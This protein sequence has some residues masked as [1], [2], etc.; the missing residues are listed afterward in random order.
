MPGTPRDIAYLESK[1]ETGDIPTQQDF[2]DLFQSFVHY[3]KVVQTEGSSTSDIMSQ[4]AVTDALNALRDGVP[5]QGNTLNKL[6]ELIL[7]RTAVAEVYNDIFEIVAD[8]ANQENDAL[9]WVVDAS[10]DDTVDSGWAIY[11]KVDSTDDF[12]NDYVKV[13]E[14]EGLDIVI[15]DANYDQKGIVEFATEAETKGYSEELAVNPYGLNLALDSRLPNGITR[16]VHCVVATTENINLSSPPSEIDGFTGYYNRGF[17]LQHPIL[18]KNQT[19]PTQNGI[20]YWDGFSALV[21]WPGFDSATTSLRNKEHW[22]LVVHVTSGDVNKGKLFINRAETDEGFDPNFYPD[23]D[24]QLYAPGGS[25]GFAISE[26]YADVAALLAGQGGQDENA[27]YLVQDAS[28]DSTVTSGWA[29][30]QKLAGSTADLA[31]YQKIAEQESLDVVINDATESVKGIVELADIDETVAGTDANRVITPLT[32]TAAYR[33]SQSTGDI[34]FSTPRVYG[35]DSLPVTGNLTHDLTNARLGFVQKIYHEDSAEPTYPSGWVKIA[36]EYVPDEL[37]LIFVEFCGSGRVEY[38]I[39]QATPREAGIF[40]KTGKLTVAQIETLGTGGGIDIV[41]APGAGKAIQ[42][43]NAFFKYPYQTTPYGST[44]DE[45][46]FEVGLS[47]LTDN[48]LLLSLTTTSWAH[49]P[50]KMNAGMTTY[51]NL[52]LKLKCPTGNPSGGDSELHYTVFYSIVDTEH[53]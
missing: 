23:P 33:T 4:K 1:F 13:Q 32:L 41:P 18:V 50:M 17:G 38:F 40:K 24:F 12:L 46:R 34:N 8:Q 37:N 42:F 16:L 49:V 6:Y 30:Y 19:D 35:T 3:L 43:H 44:H 48:F 2:Y 51:E 28:A 25:P 53:A 11:R 20:Y 47:T 9:Y 26:T 31:D 45:L 22:G 39:L 7:A 29:I 10:G 36:G 14:Q 15:T 27:W 21:R 52:P 5:A